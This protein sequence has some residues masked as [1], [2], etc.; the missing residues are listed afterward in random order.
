MEILARK[1]EV[2][3]LEEILESG[4]PE[5]VAVYG[6]RRVGKT[7]LVRNF[8]E[9]RSTFFHITGSPR[10]NT[11]QQLANFARV[12]A[13]VF[14]RGED[15]GP[16]SSWQDAFELLR[17][18]IQAAAGRSSMPSYGPNSRVLVRAWI[19]HSPW[20]RCCATARVIS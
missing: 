2:R 18:A 4:R 16:P 5:F 10:Q 9:N 15:I 12:Y 13:D 1:N 19:A 3:L 11:K 8:F 7:F 17:R 14:N 6:R 20:R